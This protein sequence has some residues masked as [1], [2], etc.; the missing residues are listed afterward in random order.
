MEMVGER[1]MRGSCICYDQIDQRWDVMSCEAIIKGLLMLS[2]PSYEGCLPLHSAGT[3]LL[4][5]PQ[6]HSGPLCPIHSRLL[7]GRLTCLAIAQRPFTRLMSLAQ[8]FD[9]S[10]WLLPTRKAPTSSPSHQ[11]THYDLLSF[12][13]FCSPIFCISSML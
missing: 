7:H 8:L 1:E 6:S 10:L 2:I 13:P 3:M 5:L 4:F 12:S 9:P 11:A